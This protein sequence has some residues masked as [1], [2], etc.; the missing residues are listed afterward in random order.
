M[1]TIDSLT[2]ALLVVVGLNCGLIA[3]AQFDL[4]AATLGAALGTSTMALSRLFFGLVGIAALYRV[5]VLM[6]WA[7]VSAR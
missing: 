5:A 2:I 6:G 3:L 1:K 7:P 4:I